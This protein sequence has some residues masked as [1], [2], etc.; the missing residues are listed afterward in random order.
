MEYISKAAESHRISGI[1]GFQGQKRRQ[2][3]TVFQCRLSAHEHQPT[4]FTRSRFMCPESTYLYEL[5]CGHIPENHVHLI[6]RLQ[7]SVALTD[8]SSL[9]NFLGS[10]CAYGRR[11]RWV[12]SLVT[13]VVH[14]TLRTG[15]ISF[16]VRVG[17]LYTVRPRVSRSPG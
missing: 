6:P 14:A 4:H 15:R 8:D 9:A 7:P 13:Q 2:L 11:K 1:S 5:P 10:C 16:R 3:L 17:C 12:A